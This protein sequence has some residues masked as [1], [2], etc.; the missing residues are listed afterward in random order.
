MKKNIQFIIFSAAIVLV[1]V[2][3][4]IV[5]LNIPETD[6]SGEKIDSGS[7]ILLYDKTGLDAEEITVKNS[8]GEYVLIG[9]NYAE[10]ASSLG[11]E[12]SAAESSDEE[13]SSSSSNKRVNK[14]NEV[15]KITMH[16]TMQGYED[17]ELSQNMTDQLAYQCSY[18]AATMLIDRTGKKYQEYGLDKPVSTVNV[19]FTD[20]SKETLYL[21]DT[22]PDSQGIYVRWSGSK[23]VYLMQLEDVNMFLIKKLQMFDKTVTKEFNNDDDNNSIVNLTISGT[24]YDKDIKIGLG[25][26]AMMTSQYAMQSPYR[27]V[28]G[29]S[30][31][32]SVGKSIYGI[33]GEEVA[34]VAVK[35]EDKKKFGL[36]KP[37]MKITA[38]AAD[39]TS[40]SVLASK[41]DE[42]GNCYV[43]AEGG[44]I[45]CKMTAE[46]VDSW[47]GIKYSDFLALTYFMPDLNKVSSV[48]IT[49]KG[50]KT[51]F[52][53]THKVELNDL[54]EEVIITTATNNGKE[55]DYANLTT[56]TDNL[57]NITRKEM[58]LKSLD[59]YEE[60]ASF[61][62]NY[63]GDEDI[64]DTLVVYKNDKSRYAVTLN[65]I[66]EGTTDGEYAEK[67][68]AQIGRIAQKGELQRLGSSEGDEES[69]NSSDSSEVTSDE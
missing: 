31:V 37:Y 40:V 55:I 28:C 33:T 38:K 7:D 11:Y 26:D 62:Y 36:D 52:K 12:S 61:V 45:I 43:M 6:D 64:S 1:L 35:D 49:Y 48:N 16:Y 63:E 3:A 39:D 65:G 32:E 14:E 47:Y 54:F 42:D 34:A 46:D 27:E 50:D 29:N 51:N 69:D 58:N 20:N 25:A 22:A 30:L 44:N 23:N 66:I 60:I 2:A 17:M 13:S 57:S 53:L 21:G 24:G 19:I 10:Q 68:F 5:V 59:G 18:A 67:V 4:L 8:S 41:V 9:F 56:F 15:V